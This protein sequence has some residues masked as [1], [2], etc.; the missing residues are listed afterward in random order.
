MRMIRNKARRQ[1]PPLSRRAT[2]LALLGRRRQVSLDFL[3]S[4]G[5]EI[6]ALVSDEPAAMRRRCDHARDRTRADN[7]PFATIASDGKPDLA[8][9]HFLGLPEAGKFSRDCE[10]F[11]S[12]PPT[13]S[14]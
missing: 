5:S 2:A 1:N 13:P 12:P 6:V 14:R 11:D 7:D 8:S 9:F 3:A 4:R 10:G